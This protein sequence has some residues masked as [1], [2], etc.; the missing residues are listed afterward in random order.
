MIKRLL[1]AFK[2]TAHRG[3]DTP[4]R[5]HSESFDQ[6]YEL[7]FA[8]RLELFRPADMTGATP[9][10]KALFGQANA[11][12]VETIAQDKTVEARIR[13]LAYSWLK[14]EGVP[15]LSKEILGVVVEVGL[16][17]GNDTLAAYADGSVRYINHSGKLAVFDGGPPEVSELAQKLLQVSR[18]TVD[19]IGPWDQPRRSPPGRGLIRLSF[20]VADGLYFGEGPYGL[21]RDEPLAAQVIRTAEQLLER[22]VETVLAK[23]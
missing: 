19:Q 16:E 17:A 20:L 21:L 22:C 8:D 13:L 10:Q 9:W 14:E 1:S 6:I 2:K 7:L 11:G 12:L 15:V 3:P 4:M 5:Q 18:A 23:A